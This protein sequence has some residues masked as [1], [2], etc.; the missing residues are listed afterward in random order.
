MA[1]ALQPD[2]RRLQQLRKLTEI[3]RALTYAVSLDDVL[4]LA[5]RRAAELLDCDKAV[6]MLA[7]AEGLLVI[8]A[9]FGVDRAAT[10]RFHEPLVETLISRLQK[11]L[12]VGP[13]RFLGVPL[14]VSG[15]VTGILAVARN[16][17]GGT[18]EDDEWLLSAV[19]DQA[20]V[21]LEKTRLDQTSEFRERLIGIVSHDLRNPISAIL[22]GTGSLLRR[23]NLD[24]R[25][26]R[27]V[28]RIHSA[29][30]RASRM[31][32]DLLDYTQA[33]FG[34]GIRVSRVPGELEPVVRQV[35][36]ELEVAHPDRSIELALDG[37]GRGEWDTD[38]MA[39]VVGNLISNAL[40]YSPADSP[41]R[42]EMRGED[43]W[44]TLSVH[45]YGAA[46]PAA[47]QS[48]IFEPMERAAAEVTKTS[49]SV[50][51]GLFI[52]R[53]LVEAHRGSITLTSSPEE[54]TT[55][56]VRLPRSAKAGAV[57]A[58][59]AL[60]DGSGESIHAE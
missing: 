58:G 41:V 2:D 10:E 45:N 26:T 32:G 1:S 6:L 28:T 31:V 43:G 40:N 23:E 55:F 34:G 13:E 15:Q 21:A 49:R 7:D 18:S 48:R 19:A 37:D 27:M 24:E 29:A 5:V 22:V 20:A 54:G 25:T 46:I 35:I 8:R 38:R 30:E 53:H 14:V 57:S 52:V 42:V 51:L 16:D 47:L 33:R 11:L 3:S 9:A 17:A 50:G 56:T 60:R 4:Q 59:D 12:G 39:Q 36:E 44:V